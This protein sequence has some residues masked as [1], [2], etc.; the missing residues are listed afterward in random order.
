[1]DVPQARRIE[2]PRWLNARVALGVALFVVSLAGGQRLVADAQTLHAMWVAERDL[3]AGTV[4]GEGDLRVG[5][6]NLSSS[7]LSL[8]ATGS[9]PVVGT[10]VTD[11]VHAGEMVP[12]S[13]IAEAQ[14]AVEGR[15]MTIPVGDSGLV[16]GDLQPGDRV[17]VLA[18]F[19][20]G[21]TGSVTRTIV[22]AAEVIDVLKSDGFVSSGEAVA[23]VT[24]RVAPE[25]APR[26]AFAIRNAEIDLA[27]VSGLPGDEVRATITE[28]DFRP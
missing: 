8:Y 23:G 16:G 20:P 7:L 18:T 2:R 10:V 15:L 28:G 24:I 5:E 25:D 3:P 19:M 21:Q 1:M 22:A 9:T 6:V 12:I 27:I 26:L 11:M 4:I 17:D 14:D 13:G